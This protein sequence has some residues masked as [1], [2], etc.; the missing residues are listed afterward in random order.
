[1]QPPRRCRAALGVRQDDAG[2]AHGGSVRGSSRDHA[3]RRAD[4]DRASSRASAR[5]RDRRVADERRRARRPDERGGFRRDGVLDDP[6]RRPLQPDGDGLDDGIDGRG[7]W[8]DASAQRVDPGTRQSSPTSRPPDRSPRG[9][10]GTTRPTAEQGAD[11]ARLRERHSRP[12]GRGRLDERRDPPPCA[13]RPGRRAPRAGGLRSHRLEAPAAGRHH[14][15]RVPPHG[16]LLRS[17]RCPRRHGGTRVDPRRRCA[18]RVR[19]AD[20]AN[21]GEGARRRTRA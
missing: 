16:G 4:A 9:P 18:H 6:E 2:D 5:H 21:R 13:R 7:A 11:P 14:A 1:M 10:D 3:D 15:R 20:S 8:H 12:V 17:R 19:H